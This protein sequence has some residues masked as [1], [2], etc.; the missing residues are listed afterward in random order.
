M[1]VHCL[2]CFYG[3]GSGARC[4]LIREQTLPCPPP[5][6]VFLLVDRYDPDVVDVQLGC[7]VGAFHASVPEE[8]GEARHA[9]SLRIF[10]SALCAG[11]YGAAFRWSNSGW[12]SPGILL[13]E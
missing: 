7:A 8:E 1:G 4:I 11:L 3:K 6:T 9:D 5:A 2:F 12:H 13:R 10:P